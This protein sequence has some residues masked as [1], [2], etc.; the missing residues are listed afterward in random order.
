LAEWRFLRFTIMVTVNEPTWNVIRMC[1]TA[2]AQAPYPSLPR[3]RESSLAP[4]RLLFQSNPLR[5]ALIGFLT[6]KRVRCTNAYNELFFSQF[7]ARFLGLNVCWHTLL[8]GRAVKKRGRGS[9]PPVGFADS[10]PFRKGG[11]GK[12]ASGRRIAPPGAKKGASP[13]I[14]ISDNPSSSRTAKF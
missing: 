4:L 9:I 5:W 2:S 10:P 13:C 1:L 8:A 12:G 7:G 14:C 3:K 6:Q 11:Q